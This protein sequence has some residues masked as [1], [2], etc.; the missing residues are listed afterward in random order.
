M[1]IVACQLQL[2]DHRNVQCTTEGTV[3]QSIATINL[4]IVA[5]RNVIQV[6][7]ILIHR[8]PSIHPNVSFCALGILQSTG[9]RDGIPAHT[10]N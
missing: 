1:L 9:I 6:L 10:Y 8:I 2:V 7:M 4:N 3:E 5:L